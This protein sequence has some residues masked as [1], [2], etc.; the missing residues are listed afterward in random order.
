MGT[1]ILRLHDPLHGIGHDHP[2][3]HPPT[4]PPHLARSRCGNLVPKDVLG[5]HLDSCR[6]ALCILSQFRLSMHAGILRLDILEW[7]HQGDVCKSSGTDLFP[8]GD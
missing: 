7:A 4:L 8:R 1:A 2:H 5:T 3:Q 6:H